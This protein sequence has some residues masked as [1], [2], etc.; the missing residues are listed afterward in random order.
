ML[1]TLK[2]FEI[3]LINQQSGNTNNGKNTMSPK[4]KETT[5][6][7]RGNVILLHQRGESSRKIAVSLKI[8]KSTVSDIIK[9]FK[10][11]G[12][13]E[14]K[15]GRGR[16]CK[17]TTR[18]Q[19]SIM[20]A[21]KK[22]PFISGTKL[23]KNIEMAT[24]KSVSS[25]TVIN[26]L[27]KKNYHSRVPSKKPFISKINQR[28][29]FEYALKYVDKPISFWKKVLFTDESKFNARG[30]D[31]RIRV[32]REPGKALNLKNMRGTVKHGGAS[33]MIWGAMSYKGVGT[34]EVIEGIMCKEHYKEILQRNMKK[35]SR[36]LRMG[37]NF[38]FMHDNDPKHKSKLVT[39]YLE[40]NN[41]NVL[42]HP[43][44]SPDLNVIEHLWDEMGRR[45]LEKEIRNKKDLEKEL[46]ALWD[47]ISSDVTQ[48]LVES[49][50]RRLQEVIRNKG[51][52]T[53]Y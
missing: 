49:M 1:H 26:F 40:D 28:K 48:K 8:P 53:S 23:A 29:R 12:I 52:P 33:V 42:D 15:K 35:S 38:I 7:Q 19:S 51:G 22:D 36:K 13:I 25:K 18:D 24:G 10:T 27:K 11:D 4:K 5:L 16:K 9:K 2:C 3:I 21:V 39:E 20:K 14:N 45:L 34:M 17:L 44:S 50:P 37:S 43:P 30:S 46:K 6:V 41:V 32:F 31:G 47:D